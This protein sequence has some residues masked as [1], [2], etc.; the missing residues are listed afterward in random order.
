MVFIYFVH[1]CLEMGKSKS[2]QKPTNICS[3]GSIVKKKKSDQV[4][5]CL[6]NDKDKIRSL[7]EEVTFEIKDM[8][9]LVDRGNQVSGCPYYASRESIKYAQVISG[10]FTLFFFFFG[11][12]IQFLGCRNGPL[13]TYD[14]SK[15]WLG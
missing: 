2:N 12:Q 15:Y 11:D 8:E 5:K 4:S 3:T 6:Y 9:Q 14:A 7:A 13:F 1:R 10:N